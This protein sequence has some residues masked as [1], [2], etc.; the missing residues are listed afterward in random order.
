MGD[1]VHV[2]VIGSATIGLVKL[3]VLVCGMSMKIHILD[4]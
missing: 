2:G 1:L 4:S 3:K